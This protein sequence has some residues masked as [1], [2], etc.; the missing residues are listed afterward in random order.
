MIVIGGNILQ[1]VAPLIA[2]IWLLFTY[3][4]TSNKEQ[5]FWLLLSL[6]VLSYIIGQVIWMFYELILHI[7]AP[8]PSW[9]DFFWLL[10]SVFYCIAFLYRMHN[11]RHTFPTIRLFL[12]IVTIM[13]VAVA[14]SW[15][16]I[17]QPLLSSI[18]FHTLLHVFAYIGYP[19]SDFGL[20]FGALSLFM[21]AD[22]CI[23]RKAVFLIFLGLWIQ[24]IADIGLAFFSLNNSFT[25]ASYLNPL[26]SLSFLLVGLS[27]LH[28]KDLEKAH[29]RRV[30]QY[31]LSEYRHFLPY[32][33]IVLLIVVYIIE[34]YQFMD[35]LAY[36]LVISVL[37]II[38]RLI[39]TLFHNEGLLKKQQ[40]LT[41]NILEKNLKL[42][43]A[44]QILAEQEQQLN[45]IFDNVDAVIWS[46]DFRTKQSLASVGVEA[47]FGFP[48]EELLG[49]P[50]IWKD[51]VH[52]EDKAKVE[53]FDHD[54][55]SNKIDHASLEFRLIQPNGQLKWIEV[56]RTPIFN[57]HRQLIKMH[58]VITDI[59][60]RKRS[61]EKIHYMAYY[62]ELTGLPNR[63]LFYECL[64][65][66]MAENK[67]VA[68]L[69]ID[70]DRFK[71]VND[72]LGHH[73]G[74]ILLK[75]VA[76]QLQ[77]SVQ[78]IG[79]VCR[80]G[81][82]EF[83]V[84]LPC[85]T[86][87]ESEQMA[88]KIIQT[89]SNPI[90]VEGVELFITPSIGI[91]LYPD[92]GETDEELLKKA[93]IAMY[94]TKENGKNNYYIYTSE[95]DKLNTR[96]V[97]IESALRRAIEKEEFTLHYQPKVE[98]STGTIVGTEALLRWNHHELGSISPGEFIPIAE[99]IGMIPPI[100]EWVLRAACKQNKEWQTVGYPPIPMSVNVSA[101][102][103]KEEFVAI[104]SS[105]LQETELDPCYLEL[106][107]T[108]SVMQNIR[109]SSPI[110]KKLKALGIQL[111][112]DD[113]GTGYSSLSYLNSLPVDTVKIDKSFIDDILDPENGG[114][115]VKTIIDMG[116]NL[117]FEVIAEGIETK[118]Q[119]QFLQKNN[120]HL[121]Q[122]Y[123][124]S[125]PL[126]ADKIWE[127]N[128]RFSQ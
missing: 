119:N 6:G 110:L 90:M 128:G 95:L 32:V 117:N 81:G 22:D 21:I 111:S 89:L 70:L 19:I 109:H 85:K 8:L 3:R 12:D 108:E 91:S 112:I 72:T 97:K 42:E 54:T 60:D 84:I 83:T 125:P 118:Q 45:E 35:A 30:L 99:D 25:T 20:L 51:S 55:S 9:A 96:K 52:P 18:E 63:R 33:P 7:E 98:L 28:A 115:M 14:I 100:G 24:S 82:D 16:F 65:Q 114:V 29:T 27:G 124:F 50:F 68:L 116:R 80:M 127:S 69:F 107:I 123:L 76:E 57:E 10:Q 23:P 56:I 2:F 48:R 88:Q 5:Y 59:T 78:G 86:T 113:F 47:I 26:W 36:G 103:L 101:I 92:H 58:A 44:L 31:K 40:Q 37:L 93:D 43:G 79:T 64:Q 71:T 11:L 39:L 74:N 66:K 105:V 67:K 1:L 53:K 49:S 62:D 41:K 121:G 126:P 15:D 4:K 73:V 102:Q 120:C 13:V 17:V 87:R 38:P 34:H 104:V 46:Y 94:Y 77:E 122:G 75:M 61:E 106:E